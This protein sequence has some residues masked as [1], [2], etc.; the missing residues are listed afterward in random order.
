L[1]SDPTKWAAIS[2]GYSV[3][4]K[5]T[6]FLMIIPSAFLQSM[7]VFTAQNYGAGK[8]E[9]I[10]KAF[11]YMVATT[12]LTGILLSC[13]TIFG[14]NILASVFTGDKEAIAYA[15]MYLK[16]FSLDCLFGSLLLMMLGFFNGMGHANFVMIQG[17]VGA[18]L[19]RIPVVLA[20]G[21]LGNANLTILGIGCASA[22]CGALI[23]CI[24]YYF[25][26]VRKELN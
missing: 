2:A 23:L 6:A 4:N 1:G 25:M 26:K 7:A 20:I 9:R 12:F 22:T 13:L 15:S 19:I 16:G 3:D 14:G 18:F 11:R 17:L 24:G 10:Q 21:H 5:I 8:K